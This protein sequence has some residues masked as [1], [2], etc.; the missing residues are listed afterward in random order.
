MLNFSESP[1]WYFDVIPNFDKRDRVRFK[2]HLYCAWSIF[3]KPFQ[4]P[5]T[6]Q[7]LL[8]TNSFFSALFSNVGFLT[9]L[10]YEYKDNENRI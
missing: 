7:D 8:E 2:D 9:K 10:V 4:L 3:T 6:A 5:G 1:G